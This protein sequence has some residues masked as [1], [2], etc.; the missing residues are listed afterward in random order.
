MKLAAKM[1]QQYQPPSRTQQPREPYE[2]LPQLNTPRMFT[3]QA[4]SAFNAQALGININR[5][6]EASD[7]IGRQ[8]SALPPD[9]QHFCMPVIHPVTGEHIT[10]YMK[11]KNDP[12]TA[13]TWERSFGKEFGSLAQGDDLTGEKGTNTVRVMT[14]AE[15]ANIPKHK[16]VTYAR[17]VADYREQKDDPN[18]IRITAGGNLIKTD[19]ELTMQTADMTTAKLM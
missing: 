13:P 18:R 11:L 6:K 12:V 1:K 14:H 5:P 7:F 15:I 10:N 4:L 2:P 16:V 19:M 8:L 9:I 3:Q 17:I